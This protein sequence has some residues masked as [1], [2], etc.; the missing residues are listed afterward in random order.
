MRSGVRR[1]RRKQNKGLKLLLGVIVAVFAVILITVG[2]KFA[3]SG[4]DGLG[5]D[6]NKKEDDKNKVLVTGIELNCDR[7][8]VRAGEQLPLEVKV[9]PENATDPS[10][11]WTVSGDMGTVSEDGVFTPSAEAGKSDVELTATAND[12]TQ[13]FDSITIRVLE[14]IDPSKPM[15]AVTYDDGPNAKNTPKVL[16]VLEKNYA[17]ATFFMV[18]K[19]I[20]GNEDIVRRS[21]E[22][23]NEM[24]NHTWD[25]TNLNKVGADAIKKQLDDTDAAI[26][27]ICNVENPILRPPY[28][29]RNET[30][31]STVNKPIVL[32]SLDTEDWKTRSADSTYDACMGAKDGDI[33]LMHDIHECTAIA[34]EDI[35]SG[36]Q[37]KGFQLVT[38][39]EL[40]QYRQGDFGPGTVN[41]SMTLD[42]YNKILEEQAA[43][44]T[45]TVPGETEEGSSTENAAEDTTGESTQN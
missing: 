37:E 35:I 15:V 34:A 2:I 30:V 1:G 45:E 13:V 44:V 38:V 18:G 42:E 10:L 11:T 22:M 21:Y 5:K 23:G 16:D 9:T 33:I 7:P 43:A 41:F 6:N 17:V 19:N 29:N 28:G 3:L 26:Q 4:L 32:W 12:G 39:S 40:Y 27:E 14:E 25:H 20:E 24:G 31:K 36:L 8:V